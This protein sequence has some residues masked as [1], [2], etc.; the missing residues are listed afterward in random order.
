MKGKGWKE[1]WK[2]G[3]ATV[4]GRN[5]SQGEDRKRKARF[6]QSLLSKGKVN[7]KFSKWPRLGTKIRLELR[8]LRWSALL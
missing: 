3:W 2:V 1:G 4:D 6:T 7:H 5:I 8:Y